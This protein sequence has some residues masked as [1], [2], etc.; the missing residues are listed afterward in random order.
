MKYRVYLEPDEDGVFVAH[1]Q[2][3]LGAFHKASLAP[4]QQATFVKPLKDI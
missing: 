4:K 3:Y 2:R 1:A